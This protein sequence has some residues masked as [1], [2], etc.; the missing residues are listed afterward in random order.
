V[1][2]IPPGP[3]WQ[4]RI[5]VVVEHLRLKCE[6][7]GERKGVLEMRRMY[8]GYFKAFRGA[9]RLRQ[10]IMEETTVEGVL[11]VLISEPEPEPVETV[12][13]SRPAVSGY[14]KARL[15]A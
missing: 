3:S 10:R 13:R 7:L 11:D 5:S 1:G 6:W 9:S 12:V 14:K 8:G 2:E 4:E 15:P